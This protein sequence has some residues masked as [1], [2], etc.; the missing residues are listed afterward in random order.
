MRMVALVETG[1]HLDQSLEE[2]AALRRQAVT[3]AI[4]KA[5]EFCR[6]LS[7]LRIVSRKPSP[8]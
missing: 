1:A 7:E 3:D 5:R 8:H 4:G 2:V 6:E